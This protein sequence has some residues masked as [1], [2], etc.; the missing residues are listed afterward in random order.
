MIMMM[1]ISSV[2]Q[3][4]V[5]IRFGDQ[6]I[7]LVSSEDPAALVRVLLSFTMIDSE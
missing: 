6:I 7:M 5:S 2:E 3:V 4:F 1:D